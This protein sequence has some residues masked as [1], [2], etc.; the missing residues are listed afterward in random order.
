MNRIAMQSVAAK[1]V[2]AGSLGLFLVQTDAAPL[3]PEL[4]T[5]LPMATLSGQAVMRFWGFDVYRAS[6]WVAPGFEPATFAQ[7]R[8]ALELRYL[9]A[10]RGADIARRSI[11]EMQRQ[12]ALEASQQSQWESRL[13]A[14][15]PDV[16]AGDRITGVYQPDR[17]ADFWL[18]GQPLGAIRDNAFAA[19]FFAI[20]LAPETSEPQLRHSLLEHASAPAG[21]GTGP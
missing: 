8:F 10:F 6:L 5:A 13:K 1:L 15:F 11:V 4:Q 7:G 17:G 14:L 18:N 3:P 20:W 19:R 16:Q 21:Q 9:R 12:Q 2:L